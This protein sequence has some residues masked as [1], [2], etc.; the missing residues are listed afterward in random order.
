MGQ[1]VISP[2]FHSAFGTPI[3]MLNFIK[4]LRELSGGKPIGFK[5]CVGMKSQFL[6]LCKAMVKTGITPDFITVDGGEGGTGAA[7]LEFSNSVGMPLRDGLA[8]VHDALNGFSLRRH[9]RIIASGKVA[10]GFDIVK[11]LALGADMCNSARAMMLA[12]GCIQAL[13]CNTNRCPTG[14]A[15]QDK[16]LQKGLVVEDKKVRVANFHAETVKSAV[17]L[18]GA[19]GISEPS[20]IHRSF[21]YR[22]V[23][24]GEIRTYAETYPYI[25]RGSL[26]EPPYPEQYQYDLSNCNEETFEPLIKR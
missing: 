26:L 8:F 19:A 23:S 16:S 10:T 5:L 25:L 14:V 11:L 7:P 13:E 24:A 17:E 21:I 22:R 1:D 6:A 9:I 15:T 18:L 12:V 3:E 2:P 20:K 4:Q